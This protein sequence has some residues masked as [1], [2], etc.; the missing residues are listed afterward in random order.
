MYRATQVRL[1]IEVV[2]GLATWMFVGGIVGARLFFVVQKW[3]EFAFENPL[4]MV[5]G[6]VNLAEGGLVVYGS[7][8]GAMAG[9]AVVLYRYQLPAL[10]VCD[11]ISASMMF[12]L[13]LGRVGCL[14]NGCCYG[15]VC[16]RPW[17]ITFPTDS[18]PYFDQLYQGRLHGFLWG[19][20]E[21]Q[22]VVVLE[23]G[24]G[25]AAEQAGLRVGDVLVAIEGGAV[26]RPEFTQLELPMREAAIRSEVQRQLADAGRVIRVQRQDG[27]SLTWEVSPWPERSLPIHPTQIY[28][29]INALLLG[30]LLWFLYPLRW[31]DGQIFAALLGCYAVARFTLE[32]IRT[33]EASFAG[34]GLTIAQN[35]SL[36]L[37]AAA[38]VLGVW[39]IW[40]RR[41]LWSPPGGP[42]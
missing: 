42:Q 29:A 31:R 35:V 22:Q 34:T 30:L 32:A 18:P 36:L 2:I 3:D 7:F 9:M 14:M 1:D 25:S 28:S 41:P 24:A 20:D 17:A 33:D 40:Q 12:G 21:Q 5:I 4:D 39:I 8:F 19:L 16:D 6:F 26:E 37:G 10:P 15:G 23:I 13:A 27:S 38:M 11:L